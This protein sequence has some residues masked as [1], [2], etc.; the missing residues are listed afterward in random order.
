MINMRPVVK[1]YAGLKPTRQMVDL[2]AKST[3]IPRL[4]L[5]V[6]Q[7]RFLS[8]QLKQSDF[9]RRSLLV[10]G[11]F[12]HLRIEIARS[13]ASS[14]QDTAQIKP[15][16]VPV[17]EANGDYRDEAFL[18]REVGG[19][20]YENQSKLP[21]LTV[22]SLVE[23]IG[24]LLPAARPLAKSKEEEMAFQAACATFAEEA[25]ELQT[26]LMNRRDE[27]KES[28]WLQ[29][30]WNQLAYLQ[31]RDSVVVNVSYFF[32]F[33]DD[34]TVGV[35][36]NQE[37]PPNV[38]R[39]AALL[40]ASGEF[41]KAVCSG[42]L[43][44]E[45]IGK[46]QTPLDATAYKYMFNA[47]RIPQRVQDSYR[48]YDPSRHSHAIVARK[49][50]FFAV[51]FVD[52]AGSP[53]PLRALEGQLKQC[54]EMADALPPAR[55]KLGIL[56]STNRDTWAD[57]RE[58][59]LASGGETIRQAL[60]MLESGAVLVCLDDS[61]YRTMN[62]CSEMFLTGTPKSGD[63]RWFDKSIQLIVDNTGRA[64][65]LNEHSMMDGMPVV[66]YADYI[67]LPSYAQIKQKSRNNESEGSHKPRDIFADAFE[68]LDPTLI[69]GLEH[70]G[71]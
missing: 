7:Q 38:Q 45:T 15:W 41:R 16:T 62:E 11:G 32:H 10:E 6:V 67:T 1:Q 42:S 43:E 27:M 70:N 58:S 50:H 66:R 33:K 53:L 3:S 68:K 39:A 51:D 31:F 19:P 69:S 63:N 36:A 44:A 35:D 2:M 48:I 23:T 5:E 20:L 18:E 65:A 9:A 29:Q 8:S 57:A 54:I 34:P 22:P 49:G 30:W 37:V 17:V 55:P 24:R 64:G 26:R 60:A 46:G 28:S 61:E 59:L 13:L 47:T 40:F 56:T 12:N 71:T 25:K 21:S 14:V 4:Y 52:K